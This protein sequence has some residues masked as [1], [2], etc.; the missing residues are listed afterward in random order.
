[1]AVSGLTLLQGAYASGDAAGCNGQGGWLTARRDG[2]LLQR[3][4]ARRV[5]GTALAPG[6]ADLLEH[7]DVLI[8][9][10]YMAAT[11]DSQGLRGCSNQLVHHL[12]DRLTGSG[13]AFVRNPRTAEI[14]VR[15]RLAARRHAPASASARCRPRSA[16]CQMTGADLPGSEQK[17][18]TEGQS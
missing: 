13:D 5:A 16:A 18:I 3:I 2:R 4:Y 6:L 15:A 14:R 1:M 9:G 12:T 7:I 17:P 11:N 8:G 10:A